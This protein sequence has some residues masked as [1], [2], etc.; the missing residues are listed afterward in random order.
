MVGQMLGQ[1]NA[2]QQAGLLNQILVSLGLAALSALA[3]GALGRGP[4]RHRLHPN[5]LHSC[6]SSR[7]LRSRAMPSNASQESST[8]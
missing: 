6:R 3:G 2:T 1:S 7:S 4:A 8:R 5:K